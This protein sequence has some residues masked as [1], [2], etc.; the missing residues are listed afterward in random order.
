MLTRSAAEDII[1]ISIMLQPVITASFWIVQCV[2]LQA[3]TVLSKAGRCSLFTLLHIVFYG[4]V[5]FCFSAFSPT[6]AL[7]SLIALLLA[8]SAFLYGGAALEAFHGRKSPPAFGS[9]YASA[10]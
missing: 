3:K 9:R 2:G 8:V 10:S 6:D 4:G 5:C 1:F 7:G